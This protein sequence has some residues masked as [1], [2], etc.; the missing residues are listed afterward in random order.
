MK[1]IKMM[2]LIL[3]GNILVFTP[4]CLTTSTKIDEPTIVAET[5]EQPELITED[6]EL[7]AQQDTTGN[8]S[9]SAEAAKNL[10]ANAK[11]EATRIKQDADKIMATKTYEAEKKAEAIIASMTSK[12]KSNNAEAE[13]IYL[14]KKTLEHIQ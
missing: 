2:A 7:I 14:L 12:V 6:I 10:I 8:L 11:K 9:A 13:K 1:N 5:G 3:T 4:G